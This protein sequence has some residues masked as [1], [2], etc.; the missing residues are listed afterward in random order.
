MTLR[1]AIAAFTV[2]QR[3]RLIR[4]LSPSIWKEAHKQKPQSDH[5]NAFHTQVPRT[6][7]N[8]ASEMF[9]ETEVNCAEIG[10]ALAIN[11][12]SI[13]LM[14]NVKQMYLIDPYTT[15]TIPYRWRKKTIPESLQK[16]RL[17]LAQERL[18]R[19]TSKCTWLLE[20]SADAASKIPDNHLD[21]IYIDGKH[22]YQAIHQ[23]LSL[24]YP[25]MK[26]GGILAGHDFTGDWL[27]V[28]RAVMDFAESYNLELQT[29]QADW[30][31]IK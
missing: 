25:K 13:L 4:F 12:E 22:S 10:V 26:K 2:N 1:K 15:Y 20:P 18:Q 29:R 31:I 9:K 8:F 30:W 19:W 23:D 3:Y 24:Y 16:E 14:L 28:V 17:L 7:T 6:S 21:F 5:W 11:S 27:E